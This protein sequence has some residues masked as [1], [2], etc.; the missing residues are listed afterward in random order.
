MAA[1]LAASS[2]FCCTPGE[3][4]VTLGHLRCAVMSVPSGALDVLPHGLQSQREGLVVVG[5]DAGV[6]ADAHKGAFPGVSKNPS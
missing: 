4:V 1:R 2:T 3:T 5:G 6:D